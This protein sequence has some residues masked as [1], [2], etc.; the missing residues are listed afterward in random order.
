VPS[1]RLLLG[2]D[3]VGVDGPTVEPE[4]V[5]EIMLAL[6][7]IDDKV[8]YLISLLEGDGQDEA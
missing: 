4:D 1:C 5:K 8:N 2:D 3:D 7:R 6:M